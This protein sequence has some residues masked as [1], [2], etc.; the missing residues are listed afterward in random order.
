MTA[1]GKTTKTTRAAATASPGGLRIVDAPAGLKPEEIAPAA[2]EAPARLRPVSSKAEAK[3]TARAAAPVPD[4]PRLANGFR[5]VR[6]PAHQR[7]QKIA[8]R[9]MPAAAGTETD[10]KQLFT[11]FEAAFLAADVAAIGACLSP[12]FTWKLPNGELRY[13]REAALAE[14]E[15]RF[16]LP[17]PARFSRSVVRFE[18]T[19]ILQTYEVEYLGPDGRWR[20]SRGFDYYETGDGLITLKDAYW[21]MIP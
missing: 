5:V 12:A 20:Q 15:H 18:G 8:R 17:N 10:L 4:G 19:T 2:P 11:R 13:G 7:V 9:P 1:A 21:K 6:N 16:A 3:L 14:M